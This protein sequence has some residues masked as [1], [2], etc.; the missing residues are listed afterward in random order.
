MQSNPDQLR[1][2][3]HDALGANNWTLAAQL[4]DQIADQVTG[5][6]SVEFRDLAR[7]LRVPV[8][9]Q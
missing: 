8:R 1:Q 9:E 3:L 6:V 2:Q 4:A 5:R 7:S